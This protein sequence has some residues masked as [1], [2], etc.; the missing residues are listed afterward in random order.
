MKKGVFLFILLLFLASFSVF[1]EESLIVPIES[2]WY[3]QAEELFLYEGIVPPLEEKPCIADELIRQLNGLKS[4]N[5]STVLSEKVNAIIENLALPFPFFSPILESGFQ[6]G[7]NSETDREHFIQTYDLEGDETGPD[8][9]ILDFRSLYDINEIPSILTLGFITQFGGWSFLLQPELRASNSQL[10]NDYHITN[11]P[12]SLLYFDL[13]F[14]GRG[15][16]TYYNPPVEARLGR[17]KLH[18]GPGKWSTLTLTRYMPYFDYI[19]FRYF[20][21]WVSLSCYVISLNPTISQNESDYLDDM[22]ENDTNPESNTH[23]NGKTYTERLK[24]LVMANLILTPL[25]WLSV[26]ISQLNLVGGRPLEIYDFNPLMIFHNNY[27]EGTYS[28]PISLSATIVPYKGIKLYID[29]FFYDVPLGDEVGETSNPGAAAYQGGFTLLSTPFFNTGPGRFRLDGEVS[30]VD[31]WVYGKF[32]NLRKFTS[33]II[34][35][36]PSV[37]RFWV[38]YPLGFYLGP[39]VIDVHLCLS[40]GLPGKWEAILHWNM[41]GMGEIDLYGWGED[42]DYT[43]A[44]EYP[45]SHAPTGT[46]QWT[47]DITLS[48]N[49]VIIKNLTLS[50]WYRIRIVENQYNAEGDNFVFHYTGINAQW[51]IY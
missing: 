18:L 48:G 23:Y 9:K 32:Y 49:W 34:S 5:Q 30:Y 26:R 1:S 47:N 24:H 21:K 29:Y 4:G 13:N 19:K 41:N 2:P 50:A 46:V 6:A 43:H 15:I 28:V 42:N 37:G 38:D 36:E 22:Y 8:K 17:G 10:L 20:H 39:D 16:M 3:T 44:G 51:K 35:A 27:Q 11:L 25:S 14:P 33:R 7:F 40:Y 45:E 31:P 12:S